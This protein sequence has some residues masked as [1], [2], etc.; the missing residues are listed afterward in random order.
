MDTKTSQAHSSLQRP[1]GDPPVRPIPEHRVD[2]ALAPV[3]SD[4]K[5]TFGVPW[6]GVI[7]QAVA[8][9]RPFFLE[10]WRQ[11]QPSATTHYFESCSNA[12]RLTSWECARDRFTI[13]P[14]A[15]ALRE[16]GYSDAELAAI[17][18]TVDIFDYGNPKYLLLATAIQQSLCHGRRLGGGSPRNPRDTMPRAPI[19]QCE[20][21]PVMVEEHH[22]IG[23]LQDLYDDMKAVL[24]LP[25]INS[26]YKA[27]G[28]W[29]SCL[30]LLWRGLRTE[31]DSEAYVQVRRAV[32]EEALATVAELPYAYKVDE[33]RALDLD[34]PNAEVQQ[35]ISL[36]QWLLSGLI[37]N[38]SWY[39]RALAVD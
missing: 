13:E 39:K 33:Q 9:Y 29:P 30:E 19:R 1:E 18:Q 11:L 10:A 6:V 2:H 12:I 15:K 38:V 17:R 37:V 23:G 35:V 21:I 25:F 5:S 8:Y 32:H 7:A 24:R 27:L 28:R 31:V 14:S 4:L 26:D 36:F 34:M 3:Y 20:P 16:L 22:A